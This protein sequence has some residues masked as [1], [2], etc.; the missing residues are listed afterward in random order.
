MGLQ[1]GS[2]AGGHV[3]AGHGGRQ[4]GRST[5]SYNPR[6]MVEQAASSLAALPEATRRVGLP[7]PP[8]SFFST[9][10]V[11]EVSATMKLHVFQ[12]QL[13]ERS[14]LEVLQVGDLPVQVGVMLAQCLTILV[15]WVAGLQSP[16]QIPSGQV[17]MLQLAPLATL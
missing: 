4:R 14:T 2:K 16:L 10:P 15:R 8:S 3:L 11:V 5:S 17:L 7:A 9:I 1:H 13:A 6:R 12:A